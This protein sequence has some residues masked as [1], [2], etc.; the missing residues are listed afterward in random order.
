[1][2][3]LQRV[4]FLSGQSCFTCF[5]V[6]VYIF[7]SIQIIFEGFRAILKVLAVWAGFVK[8]EWCRNHPKILSG[9][10]FVNVLGGDNL[11]DSPIQ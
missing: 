1:M 3:V 5:Y 7:G 9:G 10:Q 11:R 8:F 6:F 2:F 4:D